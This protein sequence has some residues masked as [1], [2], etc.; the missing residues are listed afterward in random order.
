[1]IMRRFMIED[2]KDRV[3]W[4]SVFGGVMTVLAI[5]ILLS[6]LGSS[7]G[8]YM[9]DPLAEHP[10]SGIGTT[11]GIWSAVALVLS[12]IAGG[13]VAG[14]LSGVDGMIHGFLVWATTLFL[15]AILG[16]ML[17]IGAAKLTVNALG[18]VSSVAG[19]VISGAGSVVGSGITALS[20]QAED[21]FGNIDF[22]SDLKDGDI[23]QNIRTAL[24]QS[25]VK[26]LQPNYLKDQLADV[27]SD[28][29]KSIKKVIANPKDADNIINGFMDRLKK[30][31][32][33]ITKNIDR[34]DLAKA[35]ANNTNL[36]KAE[37]DKAIDQYIDII[38]KTTAEAK[39]DINKL[40]QKLQEAAQEWK[41]MKHEA[42]VAA[43]EATDTAATSALIS[44]FALLIAAVLCSAAGSWGG[45]KTQDHIE[46]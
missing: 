9:F 35:V 21:V 44:F 5:S 16:V 20:D 25:G 43:D 40:E 32:D 22:N 18:A 29:S 28:L 7:I 38:N 1:M 14:K 15:A 13:F 10:A 30:R 6:V 27:K 45:R 39:Q 34:N 8:L 36:S 37:A 11:V 3:S 23:P 41:E 4:G 31:T 24:V 46:M 17:T 33:K 12:M 19:N 42:L 26:E 2:L